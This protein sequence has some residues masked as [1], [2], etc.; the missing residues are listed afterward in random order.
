M[1]RF[2]FTRHG[3]TEWNALGR[4]CGRTDVSLSVVGRRQARLLALRLKPLP[5]EALYTS[6]L[7]RA[8]ETARFVSKAIGREPVVDVRLVEL[9]YGAWEGST[10]QE[11]N[12]TSPEI[13]R[14]WQRDPGGSAP[15]GGESGEQLIER[16]TPFLADVAQRH[17]DGNVVVVC[18]RTVNRL[19]ACHFLGVPLSEYR[20]RV[21]ME[22]AALNIFET[23]EGKWHVVT[24]NET[25][26]LAA[27]TAVPTSTLKGE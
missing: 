14:A 19:L 12:R 11:I 20:R 22:N 21:P 6:P 18:H 3:Q 26:H 5:V 25:S 24:L 1:A 17:G 27:S 13:F 16:V 15:P 23:R 10:Y 8:L 4:L 7:Q 9:N 2:Y